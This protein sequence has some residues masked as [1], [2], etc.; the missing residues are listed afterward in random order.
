M[1]LPVPVV[2]QEPGP[3]W[4]NDINNS[5]T[6]IDSHDHSNGMGVKVTPSG[7]NI[8]A[9]LTFQGNNLT[10]LR[11]LTLLSQSATINDLISVYSVNGDLYFNDNAGNHIRIT[12]SGGVNG[13]P[14][15]ITNLVSPASA[16]FVAGSET[17]V[18]QSNVNKPASMD[19]G[20]IIIRKNVVN[21]DGVRVNAPTSLS[22]TGS[23]AYDLTLP[24]LPSVQ[25]FMT[26][27]AAGLMAAPWTVDNSTIKIVANQLVANGFAVPRE[28]NW[29]LNGNLSSL[30]YPQNNIDA[31]FVVPFNITIQ[32]VWIYMSSMTASGSTEFD[33][34]VATVSG[35]SSYTSILS[36]TGKIGNSSA[37]NANPVFTD[38]GS[39]VGAQ[40]GITKP[41]IS[42]ANINAGST[43]RWDLLSANGGQDARI[44]IFYIQ[45]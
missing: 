42:T 27:D 13:S 19:S 20:S 36:T 8:S 35:S 7:L 39:V 37:T 9:D 25:S 32:S 21:S 23:I 41:V 30:S 38:S 3:D 44:R 28:H 10:N 45:R 16:T 26:L 22:N 6:L 31:A 17:F 12:A 14:G 34:K 4:A 29:E 5:L 43:I 11:A 33:L 2:G 40:T 15:S 1:N 18:W 24:T